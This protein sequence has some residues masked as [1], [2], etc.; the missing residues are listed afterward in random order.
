MNVAD[1]RN[2]L[3][4]SS[5]PTTFSNS[6]ESYDKRTKTIKIQDLKR[7]HLKVGEKERK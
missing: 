6:A 2:L 1:K 7:G 4:F 5:P 3:N